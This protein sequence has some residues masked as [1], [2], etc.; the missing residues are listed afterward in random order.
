MRPLP[1]AHVQKLIFGCF[2]CIS[3]L[4]EL[5][6]L[7]AFSADRPVPCI[8][9]FPNRG[10]DPSHSPKEPRRRELTGADRCALRFASG[11]TGHEEKRNWRLPRSAATK[12][13]TAK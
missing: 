13:I 6:G 7:A 3:E 8:G 2:N 11:R 9:G 5:I 4:Q 1:L 12:A 10:S